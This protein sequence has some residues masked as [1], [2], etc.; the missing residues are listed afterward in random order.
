MKERIIILFWLILF[1][2]SG[3][4][5]CFPVDAGSPQ[6]IDCNNPCVNLQANY[7]D[8][9]ETTS[10]EVESI[11]HNPP[12]NYDEVGGNAVSVNID[13]AWS[14]TINLPFPFCFFGNVY[15]SIIIGSNGNLNLNTANSGGYCPWGFNAN[16]PS[17]NLVN[18]GNIYG[19]YHDIDPSVCGNIKW[20]LS[21]TAPCRKFIVSFNSICHFQCNSIQSRH[22][23]VL[24]E[25][26]NFIDV[27]VESK[28]ICN[29]WNGGRAIIG[30]QNMMGTQGIT[31]PNRNSNPTWTVTTPEAWR[32]KP[33]GNPIYTIQWTDDNS[34][35]LGTDANLT[36]CPDITT[37]YQAEITYTRCDGLV[38]TESDDVII[39]AEPSDLVVT[40]L[41]NISATCGQAN[42]S[43]E[44]NASG[45]PS[46]FSYSLDNLNFVSSG[47]FS[48]LASGNY[49]FYIQDAT[50]CSTTYS[51]FVADTSFTA[52]ILDTV[53]ESCPGVGDGSINVVG[54]GGVL[55]YTYSINN[56]L[57]QN[58]GE[59]NSLN[60][61]SY[62]ITVADNSGCSFTL[63]HVIEAP[64][65][66]T[67]D[68][69]PVAPLCQDSSF[70]L[71][72]TSLNG[73][74][75]TWSPQE[76]AA[77]TTTY[78]FTPNAEQCAEIVTMEIIIN[79]L[80]DATFD[81]VGPYC[82]GSPV[83]NLLTTSL[84]GIAGSWSPVINNTQTTTYTFNPDAGQCANTQEME[85]IIEPIQATSFEQ[86]GPFCLGDIAEPLPNVSA[87]GVTGVWGPPGINTN[88]LGPTI[89]TFVSD[90]NQC[91][92]NYQVEVVVNPIPDVE[93]NGPIEICE[94]QE[95]TLTAVSG[96]SN[97]SC[98]W[99]PGGES[100]NEILVSPTQTTSY[101]VIYTVSG[102][103]S[104]LSEYTLI[105]NPN[106]PVYAGDDIEICIGE[107][108]TLEGDNAVTYSWSDGIENGVPFEPDSSATYTLTGIS[109]DGCETQDEVSVIVQAL[110]IV[111][112]G[113]DFI[114]CE[115]DDIIL[116]ATGAGPGATYLWDNGVLNGVS[117]T[118]TSS[119]QYTVIG[120]DAN[121]C[122]GSASITVTGVPN[123]NAL[124]TSNPNSGVIPLNVDFQNLSSGATNYSWDFGNGDN[125][126]YAEP[127]SPA[128]SS[129]YNNE[130]VYPVTLTAFNGTCS[131]TFMMEIAA[132]L[133][134][135]PAI[136][137]PNVFS[138]NQDGANEQFILETENVERL[139]L[140]ILNRWGN[141]MAVIE[142]LDIGWDGRSQSGNEAKAGI[143]FY[144]YNAFGFNGQELSGHGFLTLVR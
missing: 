10:Y 28:P 85:I 57:P 118:L 25:T 115:G 61:G 93:I 13:D 21:G 110:P 122:E 55:P 23:I 70:V 123:P 4:S 46:P 113:S 60:Q 19:V 124:F 99:Q 127:D 36:V 9:R 77:I 67:P 62:E 56:S 142:S 90:S 104:P 106:V 49:T 24:S 12:I 84:E 43:I 51:S 101:S 82:Q 14:G 44:I 31:A 97:G 116:T 130:G 108:V 91:A 63:N 47:L 48:N 83:P 79:P 40:E 6:S 96:L 105:V 136:F 68:F 72:Q 8:I 16:C 137:V 100:T 114:A 18:M 34:N 32:F 15:N 88:A 75:G 120:T 66:S 134:G 109:A 53:D 89:Y 119:N 1:A 71:P 132:N 107:E 74:E 78:T 86:L 129:V 41:D 59:F 29:T 81:Q 39:T 64:Q 95:A 42:G 111:D 135:D 54:I 98:V 58:T 125:L 7:T 139:E 33:S 133:Y 92:L 17:P 140:I 94:G 143:Y 5:Q 37:T 69:E 103:P 141:V 126:N 35:V 22:M 52:T 27:Y 2:G 65:I 144:K 128:I 20:Y 11:P 121:G 117:F 112:P 102:C 73:I 3:F 80:L 138:P 50:G 131:D 76:N 26:S 38:I 30:I 45:G 87:Q